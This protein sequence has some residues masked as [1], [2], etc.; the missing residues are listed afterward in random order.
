MNPLL[1]EPPTCVND[2]GTLCRTVFEMTGNAWLSGAVGWLANAPLRIL[3]ILVVAFVVRFVVRRTIDRLARGA[4]NGKT[5]RILRPLKERAPQTIGALVSERRQQRAQT[6]GSVMKSLV[7]FLVWGLAFMLILG[8]IGINLGPIIAS[9]GIVGVALGFGAQNLVKDFLSGVFMMLEDQYGVGDIVDVGP[10]TG[11]IESVGLR[12]T[13]L[14]D[15]NGTVWYVR[16]GEI[17]RVGNSSQG[18]A[19]AVVDVP[20]GYSADIEAATEV[21][22]RIVTDE[23]GTEPVSEDVLEPPEVLGVDKVTPESI[24]VRLTVKVRAGRQWAVQRALRARII[25][26]LEEAGIEPPLGR[27]YGQK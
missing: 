16:N 17:L 9:A 23:T 19:V 22:K 5:P 27:L 25:P 2:I 24:T 14:R 15:V 11:T 7:S 6:I 20:L 13:T 10:A 18:F 21:I 26:A 4:S 12:V 3:I 8:E 1:S